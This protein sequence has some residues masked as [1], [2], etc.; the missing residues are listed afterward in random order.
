MVPVRPLHHSPVRLF[1]PQKVQ[2]CILRRQMGKQRGKGGCSEG[3]ERK[4]M[5]D[6]ENQGIVSGEGHPQCHAQAPV[7][8]ALGTD[9]INISSVTVAWTREGGG[10][11]PRVCPRF[12]CFRSG[13]SRKVSCNTFR[14]SPRSIPGSA[15]IKPWTTS[16]RYAVAH[17]V[18]CCMEASEAAKSCSALSFL[19][20][21]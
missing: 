3:N 1:T 12:S 16:L 7:Q 20:V 15:K 18:R 21:F 4:Q 10:I 9:S 6:E 11:C 19:L 13:M 8:A 5:R 14:I 17:R 2:E